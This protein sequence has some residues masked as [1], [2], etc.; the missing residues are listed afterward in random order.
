MDLSIYCSK[1]YGTLVILLKTFFSCLSSSQ[2]STHCKELG[3]RSVSLSLQHKWT[4]IFG[5]RTRVWLCV[6]M[7]TNRRQQPQRMMLPLFLFSITVMLQQLQGLY[8]FQ[9][10]ST[11]IPSRRHPII[12]TILSSSSKTNNQSYVLTRGDGSTGGGGR[13]MPS[14]VSSTTKSNTKEDVDEDVILRRPKVGAEMP[15]GRPSWFKVPA[16]SQGIN[17]RSL[18]MM[19][20]MN[21]MDP[22]R[23]R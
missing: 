7:I 12:L 16:P 22:F 13:P 6:T 19:Q 10:V 1:T 9:D 3:K 20:I 11:R 21:M 18:R 15:H 14:S 17:S 4:D 8:S 23:C 2:R 5:V